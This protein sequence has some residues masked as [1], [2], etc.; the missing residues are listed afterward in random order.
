MNPTV[1][2]AAK[3]SPINSQYIG[4]PQLYHSACD[5]RDVGFDC[6]AGSVPLVYGSDLCA[7]IGLHIYRFDNAAIAQVFFKALKSIPWDI[8]SH[9]FHG[10]TATVFVIPDEGSDFEVIDLREGDTSPS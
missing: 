5:D 2:T 9:G 3:T 4:L 8:Y 10:D 6:G 7:E 1:E